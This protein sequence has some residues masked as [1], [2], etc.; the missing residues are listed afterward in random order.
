MATELSPVFAHLF[1]QSIDKGEIPKE[2]SLAHICPLFKNGDR[3]LAC[4]YRPVSLTCVP[5]KLLEHIVCSNIM[6]HLDEHRLLSEKQHAFRKRHSCETQLTTVIDD[7]TKIL[8]NQGQV[9]IFI[10]DFEKAFDTPLN[11]NSLLVKRQT[12]N[13]SPGAVTGGN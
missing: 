7:W 9:D 3:P 11:L 6:A 8:D 12:D 1:Q 10:L 5:C 2:W 13:P 4:N